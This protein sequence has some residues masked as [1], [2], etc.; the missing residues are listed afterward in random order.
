MSENI[1]FTMSFVKAY[2]YQAL[3][4]NMGQWTQPPLHEVVVA[5]EMIE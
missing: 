2:E 4:M 1:I 5:K 3:I